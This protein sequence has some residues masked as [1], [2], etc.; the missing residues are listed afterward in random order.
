MNYL[1]ISTNEGMAI[2]VLRCLS[3]HNSI[4]HVINV[5]ENSESYRFS[6]YCKSYSLYPISAS[7]EQSGD[8]IEIVNE[9]CKQKLSR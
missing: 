7:I 3:L 4:N 6:R 2:T 1:I 8:F 5:G 9:Y